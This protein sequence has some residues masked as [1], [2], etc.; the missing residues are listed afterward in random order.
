MTDTP[1]V[2]APPTC[3]RHP[4]RETYIRCARC[5]RP[6]CPDCMTSASVGFQCPECIKEGAASVREVRTVA[7][8]KVSSSDGLVT[9]IIVAGTVVVFVLQ[10]VTGGVNG[11]VTRALELIGVEVAAGEYY[12]LVTVMVVHAGILHI[13]LNMYALWV[14]GPTL[15]R[16]LGRIRFATLY[17]LAGFAGGVSSYLFNSPVQPSVGASGA[18]F[19]IFGAMLVVARRMNFDVRGLAAL[20]VINLALPIVIP[21]T[22]DWRAHLGGLAAGAVVGAIFAY[23]PASV[24]TPVA[25]VGC[26]AV[27]LGCMVLVA[28]RTAQ[29]KD[30]PRYGPI[31][32]QLQDPNTAGAAPRR[33]TRE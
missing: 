9:R 30:S 7:G 8:G 2:S 11:T 31:V 27:L 26:L 17:L 3:Y 4:E 28:W 16:W 13:L 23:P 25:V 15:E 20:I 10:L 14:M 18:I 33:A 6:I 32:E 29:I 12:R 24:R 5:E 21:G 19:G 22:I 1:E